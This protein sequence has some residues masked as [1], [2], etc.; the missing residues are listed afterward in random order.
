MHYSLLTNKF[1]NVIPKHFYLTTE[2]TESTVGHF[3]QKK[4][5]RKKSSR[6]S[7]SFDKLQFLIFYS[8][9]SVFSSRP[10]AQHPL[11]A[12]TLHQHSHGGFNV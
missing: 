3:K 7:A 4:I 10:T 12:D 9:L 1:Y 11:F 8:V 2:D 5:L 6:L